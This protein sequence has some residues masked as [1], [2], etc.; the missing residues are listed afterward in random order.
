MY[1]SVVVFANLASVLQCYFFHYYYYFYFAWY[2]LSIFLCL[3]FYT[4]MLCY[5][6]NDP[7]ERLRTST[8]RFLDHLLI[9]IQR[10]Y[11]VRKFV[12]RTIPEP[13]IP[14]VAVSMP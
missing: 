5:S 9:R 13:H 14:T 4:C 1:S 6:H 2:F 12:A 11:P 3:L 7:Y 10:P 8:E